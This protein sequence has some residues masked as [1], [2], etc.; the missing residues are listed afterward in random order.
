VVGAKE[1][2]NKKNKVVGDLLWDGRG[3]GSQILC[4]F[5][6]LSL[7]NSRWQMVGIAMKNAIK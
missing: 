3:V 4:F 1:K 5:C 6:F 7:A 2:K